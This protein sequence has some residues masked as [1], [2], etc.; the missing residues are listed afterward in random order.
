MQQAKPIHEYNQITSRYLR[1]YY[2]GIQDIR[3]KIKHTR[4]EINN[5]TVENW[6]YAFV[7]FKKCY[8]LGKPIQYVQLND[9]G[10][11]EISLLNK[12]VKNENKKSKDMELYEDILVCGRG[13]RYTN[14]KPASGYK[15]GELPKEETAPFEIL[16]ADYDHTEVVYSNRLGNEQILSFIQTDMEFINTTTDAKTGEVINTPRMYNEYTVYLRNKK[17]I[18]SDKTGELEV[19]ERDDENSTIALNDHVITEYYLNRDRISLI[20]IGKDLF[21]DINYLESLDK[22][23]M[24][25]FVNAIMVFVN[26]EIDEEGLTNMKEL[27]AVCISS[28]ENRKASVELLQQRLNATDTQVYY[29]RLLTSLHQILGIPMSSDTGTVTSGDTGKAKLTGQ[30]YTMAGIRAEGQETMFGKC[31]KISLRK[32]LKICREATETGI[33]NLKSCDVEAKFQ[34]DM[35][36]NLLVKTQALLNLYNADIPRKFAN[37]I[38]G[39]FG[40][41]NAITKEQETLFGKQATQLGAGD[42]KEENPLNPLLNNDPNKKPNDDTKNTNKNDITSQQDN[43]LQNINERNEQGNN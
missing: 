1:G 14:F 29:T 11:A 32:I 27:G 23:D 43:K 26:A 12:Y 20:E 42:K 19:I 33:K 40:D 41:P 3:Q 6:C 30:G 34:R 4:T 10:E 8:L 24:E 38:V 22:D 17:F 16:N 13:F 37:A 35:S 7:D 5:K 18:V 2:N 15:Y 9:S 39:L 31:D 21:D 28:T 36:D 25:Q